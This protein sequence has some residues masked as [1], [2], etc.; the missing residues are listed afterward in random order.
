MIETTINGMEIEPTATNAE[1][2]LIDIYTEYYYLHSA[3]VVEQHKEVGTD[4]SAKTR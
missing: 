2:E 3:Q 1:I 4:G